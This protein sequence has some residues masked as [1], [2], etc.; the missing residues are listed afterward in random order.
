MGHKLQIAG[1]G[2]AALSFIGA[3]AFV[4]ADRIANDLE[5]RSR[6]ALD[7][8]GLP[9]VGVEAV[10]LSVQ[11]VGIPASRQKAEAVVGELRGARGTSWLD[12]RPQLIERIL[13]LVVS[14]ERRHV[15]ISGKMP[16]DGAKVQAAAMEAFGDKIEI[17]VS[18]GGKSS[19]SAD[20]VLHHTS[21]I[22]RVFGATAKS[23]ILRADD[24]SIEVEAVCFTSAAKGQLEA[25]IA[26][27][28]A[29]GVDTSIVDIS[30]APSGT[31]EDLQASLDE[32]LGRAGINFETNSVAIDAPSQAVLLT[33]VDALQSFPNVSIEVAGH[34]DN[35]G[36]P[37]TNLA[38]SQQRADSVLAFLVANGVNPDRVASVG[39]GDTEPIADNTT[40]AGLRANRRIEF[41]VKGANQ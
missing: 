36:T 15:R 3:G 16:S 30:V 8:A 39:Y 23:A 27:A 31:P 5:L 32:L 34:A 4:N 41:R 25:V 17:L 35:R 22:L 14:V 37:E 26:R 9:D 33:A 20:L 7:Q 21:E 13:D 19:P 10:G 40:E 18:P 24:R 6:S 28:S 2:L 12:A 11:L 29:E 1:I 38:L